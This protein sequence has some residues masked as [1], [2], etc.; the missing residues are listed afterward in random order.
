MFLPHAQK[1][2]GIP[3]LS[4]GNGQLVE[5]LAD[6][7]LAAF[8]DKNISHII[9]ACGSCNGG[10]GE[11]YRTMKGD[12]GAITE[13]VV[14]FSVFLKK[15]GFLE[16]L[17]RLPRWE[18]RT[19][20]TYHDPCHLKTQGI[21]EEPRAI[22]KALPNIEYVEMEGASLC[23]GLGGTFSLHHYECSKAI[24]AKKI[25]GLLESAAEKI[26]TA[27]PG[28]MIQLQDTINHASLKVES[29]HILQLIEEA[30]NEAE[31]TPLPRDLY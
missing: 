17:Y 7:N 1:C 2:C 23:C 6:A 13:K 21:T 16:E 3:G 4:V 10:I 30:L 26:A 18:K 20:V 27:C 29:V 15:E 14:D 28:C 8:S 9:T 11:Y 12:Y 22:L 31:A 5:D 19:K 25:P 24:G